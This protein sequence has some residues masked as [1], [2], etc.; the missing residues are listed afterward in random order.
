MRKKTAVFEIE[1]ERGSR[2]TKFI[3]AS[4]RIGASEEKEIIIIFE[5]ML[6]M[7]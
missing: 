4:G 6:N 1:L 2:F 5:S 7:K 3:P